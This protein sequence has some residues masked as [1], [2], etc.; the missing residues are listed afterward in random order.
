[1]L[2][3]D[4]KLL[5]KIILYC[6]VSLPDYNTLEV[7]NLNRKLSIIERSLMFQFLTR[8]KDSSPILQRKVDQLEKKGLSAA[9]EKK[10]LTGYNEFCEW[11]MN[12]CMKNLF[13]G[14]SFSRRVS[15]LYIL[16][17]CKTLNLQPDSINTVDNGRILL[18]CLS[19]TYEENKVS[20]VQLIAGN[21]TM[22]PEFQVI[23][24]IK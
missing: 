14:A 10:L 24:V 17:L 15:S 1:M 21:S 8:F 5:V 16:N 2:Y 22:L 6:E 7:N 19:D 18:S 11:L 23:T 12:F 4:L 20:A 9:E 3:K 13:P